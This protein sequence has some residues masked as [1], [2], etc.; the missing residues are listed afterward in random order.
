MKR[1]VCKDAYDCNNNNY[2]EIKHGRQLGHQVQKEGNWG[3]ILRIWMA[4]GAILKFGVLS[5]FEWPLWL[6]ITLNL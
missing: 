4:T 3:H 6:D 5:V 1:E 2:F